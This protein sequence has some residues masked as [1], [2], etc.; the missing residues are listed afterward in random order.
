[1]LWRCS[2]SSVERA[3]MAVDLSNDMPW[4]LDSDEAR[5]FLF[6]PIFLHH[7]PLQVRTA[8]P[9]SLCLAAGDFQ[10][11]AK[12]DRLILTSRYFAVLLWHQIPSNQLWRKW[13]MAGG[14]N[15]RGLDELYF[16]H[17][18]FGCKA[19][20]CVPACT[21]QVLGNA[22]AVQVFQWLIDSVMC[23]LSFTF[24]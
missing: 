12:A 23:V 22:K 1:M 19:Q 17:P 11:F 4:L 20:C 10:G 2:L 24:I 18:C 3:D 6:L 15:W 5:W 16:F 13:M 8:L 7:I 14:S 9:K 21:F